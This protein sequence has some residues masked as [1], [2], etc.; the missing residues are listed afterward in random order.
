MDIYLYNT[1]TRRKDKFEPLT[2]GEVKMYS[3]GPTVYRY[4]HIGNLRTF[5]MADLARRLLEYHG[6]R[7]TQVMN[8]TDVG[9]MAEDDSLTI[10]P[11]E[12]KVLAA[13]AAERKTPQ[14]IAEFY[15][16]DFLDALRQMNI[17]PAHIY[18]RATEHIPQML[19]L[20]ETLTANG[21]A[22]A[23]GGAVFFDVSRFEP[24]GRL[25]GHALEDLKAGISRVTIDEA[26]DDPNDF[27]LWRSAGE[28]R[29][30]KWESPW[31]PGFPGWHIEC[32]AMS[33]HYL[34]LQLDLHTGGEDLVFPHHEGE[35]AQSEGATGQPFVRYWM[36]G[37]HLLAEGRKMARSVG[38]VLRLNDLRAEGYEPLAFRL[39]CLGIYYRGHMNVT[40]DS[41]KAAQSN[42]D[43]LRRYVAD[44][45]GAERSTSNSQLPTPN[46][47]SP[48]AADFHSRFVSAV[49]D[50]LGFPQALPI[51]WEMAKSDLPPGEKLGLLLDWDRLLGLDLASAR[52][53]PAPA[54][55][56]E[57]QDLLDQRTAARAVKDWAAADRL[58]AQL[59]ERGILVKDGKEGQTW[60]RK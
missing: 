8:V 37:A 33:M 11:G 6:Y 55:E 10:T 25:S 1:L 30:V 19:A 59:A 9:H 5:L 56:P 31:G 49:A 23:K 28:H 52:A 54:L 41:L 24:Y 12:D 36:H 43:R 13:A 32:S 4:V 22:Y 35:I 29:L 2:P 38:N 15:T 40:W 16:A 51:I 46:L 45:S 34:G 3:C 17:Q 26:K 44:W 27:L 18:P 7:V 57:L 47:Q 60:S 48:L 50:D 21:L 14:E 58:R 39:L 42:L 53:A 20:I